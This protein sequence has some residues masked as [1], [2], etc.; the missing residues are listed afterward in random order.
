M[1]MMEIGGSLLDDPIP[2]WELKRYET[3][4][5]TFLN[6]LPLMETTETVESLE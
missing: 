6:F 5:T 2:D 3:K 4:G 1:T